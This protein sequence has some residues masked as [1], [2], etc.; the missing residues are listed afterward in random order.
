LV[1][2]VGFGWALVFNVHRWD[3]WWLP[4]A[5]RGLSAIDAWSGC[6]RA[7]WWPRQWSHWRHHKHDCGAGSHVCSQCNTFCRELPDGRVHLKRLRYSDLVLWDVSGNGRQHL[8]MVRF[9]E[10]TSLNPFAA[11]WRLVAVVTHLADCW[12]L[13]CRNED[14]TNWCSLGPFPGWLW[15][16]DSGAHWHN[17]GYFPQGAPAYGRMG[18]DDQPIMSSDYHTSGG[19]AFGGLFGECKGHL[20]SQGNTWVEPCAVK[21]AYPRPVDYGQNNLHS[22]D[23]KLYFT[24]MGSSRPDGPVSWMSADETHVRDK[25]RCG[26]TC[27]RCTCTRSF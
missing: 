17:S 5:V 23:G 22:P 11:C 15:S 24:S 7:C 26:V 2:L 1:S 8:Q 16:D 20:V 4:C 3:R 6:R 25:G 10:P 18:P 27:T 14:C 19:T 9:S 13:K 12:F 21:F